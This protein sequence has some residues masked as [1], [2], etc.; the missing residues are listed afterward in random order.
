MALHCQTDLLEMVDALRV[1]GCSRACCMAGKSKAINIPI[2]AM[3]TNNST[4]VKAASG[5]RFGEFRKI[6]IK[7]FPFLP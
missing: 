3:T 1:A 7:I 6:F 4:S 2:I 5:R